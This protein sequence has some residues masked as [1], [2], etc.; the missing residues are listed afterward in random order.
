M[1]E[2]LVEVLY[3]YRL[4]HLKETLAVSVTLQYLDK[5]GRHEYK[6]E[7][8]VRTYACVAEYRFIDVDIVLDERQLVARHRILAIA[9]VG[10]RLCDAEA[11]LALFQDVQEQCPVLTLAD[12]RHVELM[13]QALDVVDGRQA[14]NLV[15]TL[16]HA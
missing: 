14:A 16:Q 12:G 15:V 13:A 5:V 10:Q 2:V 7:I 9:V 3:K 6:E 4:F 11:Y 8:D 1:V